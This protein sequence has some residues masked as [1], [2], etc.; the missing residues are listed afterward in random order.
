MNFRLS[1]KKSVW[2]LSLLISS[3]LS[4]CSDNNDILKNIKGV[5]T[6]EDFTCKWQVDNGLLFIEMNTSL[7]DPPAF[8]VFIDNKTGMLI[9]DSSTADRKT[10]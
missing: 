4:S 6:T 9:A 1:F 7:Q 10:F 5:I 3:V 2:L 8:I